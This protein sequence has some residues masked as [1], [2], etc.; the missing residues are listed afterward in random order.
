MEGHRGNTRSFD[1]AGE[2][3]R[4]ACFAQDDRVCMGPSGQVRA[5]DDSFG[6]RRVYE[7]RTGEY[8]CG[9]AGG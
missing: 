2:P 1:Y 3:Y 9:D 5:Q 6:M 4:L 8:V 7:Y